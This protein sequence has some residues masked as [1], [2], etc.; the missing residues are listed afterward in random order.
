MDIKVIK[1]ALTD[2]DQDKVKTY[3]DY[4]V[5]L[6]NE[7]DK[8]KKLKNPWMGYKKD[9]ELISYFKKVAKDGLV[10]DGVHIT[11]QS[12][13]VSYDYIA[14]KNKMLLIYPETLFDIALV[15]KDDK[16]RFEKQS[17]KVVY[18]HEMSNPFDQRQENI[19]GG[20][21]II[22]NKRGEFITSLSA[23][24]IEKHR[25]VPKRMTSG[26]HGFTKCA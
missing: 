25:K 4:L 2:Y 6:A 22:V 19:I 14:Y 9:D 18:H 3:I 8:D 16:F 7:K 11:L 17:G 15:Y 10:F 26:N 20:Y 5:R 12:I 24:Q 13:G 23:S 21:C 1:N